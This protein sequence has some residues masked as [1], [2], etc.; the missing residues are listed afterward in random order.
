MQIAAESDKGSLKMFEFVR[1]KCVKSS[2]VRLLKQEISAQASRYSE[3]HRDSSSENTRCP[4]QNLHY[5]VPKKRSGHRAV[6]NNENL[7]IWG[8]FCPVRELQGDDDDEE[9]EVND[10]PLFPELWRFNFATRRWCLLET[11]GDIPDKY[12]ASHSTILHGNSI[13]VFGGTGF[14]FGENLSNNLYI[15]NLNTL[16]WKKYELKGQKPLPLYG[17][18]LLSFGDYLYILFG[19]NAVQYCSNVYRVN[20]KTLESEKLFDSIELVEN[21]NFRE[22]ENL[23]DIY[24]NDFLYGRY[25]Q[26]VIHFENKLYTFGGGKI[27]GD[28]HSLDTLPAF[29]VEINKW[30]FVPTLPDINTNTYPEKRKFHSCIQ[31]DEYV[32]V[33][34]GMHCDVENNV[35][36]AVENCLWRLDMSEMR[37]QM[38]NI[39][40][41]CLTYF[42]AAC[43]NQKGQVFIHG[44]VKSYHGTNTRINHLYTILLKLP[45]LSDIC[46]NKLIVNYP[47]LLYMNKNFLFNLGIP[48]EFIKKIN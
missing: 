28:A 5:G 44:G 45:K 10:S 27:D 3:I 16:V 22:L 19:T 2:E 9:F 31:I 42:H 36:Q 38:L 43:A 46:W 15:C 13:V 29:N 17:S 12:V 4:L 7:W 8:G 25:R 20:I 6:C 41:P 35:F 11:T 33:L 47:K 23:N 40:I 30:E 48:T 26:E 32:Y 21:S 37:W 18:S 14:P 1:M 34:G 24:P 39:Q